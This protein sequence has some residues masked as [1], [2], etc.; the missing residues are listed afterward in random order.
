MKKKL[1][2]LLLALAMVFT[3]AA[4]G[5]KKPDPGKDATATEP[6]VILHTNDVHGAIEGYAYITALKA[7]YEAKEKI[8]NELSSQK[9]GED[10][11]IA[12]V[13]KALEIVGVWLDTEFEG[14]RH[15]RRVDL[16]T[17]LEQEENS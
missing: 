10:K 5:E 4:C 6:V 8:Y 7:D 12:A 2:S 3:L 11:V 9:T 14:G 1:L 13:D 16:I 15:Q 17:K